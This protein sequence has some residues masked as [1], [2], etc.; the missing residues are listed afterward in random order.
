MDL[1]MKE[2]AVEISLDG[3]K[4]FPNEDSVLYHNAGAAFLA[5]GWVNQCIE[6]LKKGVH[7]FPDDSELKEFLKNVE[8]DLD[9]D[10]PD[11]GELLSLLLIAVAISAHKKLKKKP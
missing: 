7:K 3:L 1:A 10:P 2:E 5:M 9:N 11:G 8:N 6:I 4:R